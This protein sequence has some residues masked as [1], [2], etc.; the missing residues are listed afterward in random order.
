[1]KNELTNIKAFLHYLLSKDETDST[2]RIV[3]VFIVEKPELLEKALKYVYA[4]K[5]DQPG[6]DTVERLRQFITENKLAFNG[7]NIEVD[8]ESVSIDK[9]FTALFL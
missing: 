6:A 9:V 5:K 2:D 1:M 8:L 4:D 7:S 3:Y